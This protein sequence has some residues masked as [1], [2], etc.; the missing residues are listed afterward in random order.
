M[1]RA[2]LVIITA[3]AIV[4]CDGDGR[5]PVTGRV[6][7]PDGSP[8]VNGQV[9]VEYGDGTG[10]MGWIRPDGSFVL[11]TDSPDDGLPPGN[12]PV[13]IR[14]ALSVPPPNWPEFKPYDPFPLVA[15]KYED[16]K[17]SGISFHLP[18]TTEWD[19]VV[20]KP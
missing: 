5:I 15:G 18:E 17:T 4:G 10:A 20:E 8:V 2:S 3:L 19:I 9:V 13:A 16:P 1:V 11:G 6:H 7:Y 12:H 14:N